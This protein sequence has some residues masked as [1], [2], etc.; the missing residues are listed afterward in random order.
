MI[1]CEIRCG[2]KLHTY[3]LFS[4]GAD[5][6]S[7]TDSLSLSLTSILSTCTVCLAPR[8]GSLCAVLPCVL[9]RCDRH[10]QTTD[11]AA[12]P[13]LSLVHARSAHPCLCHRRSALALT[14]TSISPARTFLAFSLVPPRSHLAASAAGR[15]RPVR[16]A[17]APQACTHVCPGV[18][19][20]AGPPVSPHKAQARRNLGTMHVPTTPVVRPEMSAARRK[21]WERCICI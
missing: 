1:I 13:S 10:G 9:D 21:R 4:L 6:R 20:S 18:I 12:F 16:C 19:P 3:R 15:P 7:D 5:A 14:S 8:E 11:W 2:S 17:C